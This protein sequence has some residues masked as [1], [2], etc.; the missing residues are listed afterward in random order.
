MA[1][2]ADLHNLP[3]EQREVLLDIAQFTLDVIGIVEPTPFADLTSG[4]ISMFRG[5]WTGAAIS[6]V[7]VVPYIGDL[8]KLGKV[9][10][11]LAKVENAIRLARTNE[12]FAAVLRPVLER[13]RGALDRLPL[14]KV[15]VAVRDALERMRKTIGDFLPAGRAASRLDGLTDDVLRRVFGSTQ[16]VGLLPRQNVRT[17]VEFFDRYKVAG[18][19]AAQWAELLKGIDLHAATPI[20]VTKFKPGELVAEYVELARPANRQIG[21]W[22]VRAQ[23]AVSHRNIGLSG[24]GRVRKVYRVKPGAEVEV[25]QSKAAGAADHWTLAGPKPHTAVTVQNGQRVMKDAEHVAGGGE[26]FFLPNAWQFLEE[27]AGH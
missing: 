26:Q 16:N 22:M 4:V 24:A 17:T 9:P 19:D 15:P 23:G 5:D 11:Y 21:Q 13:L 12:K 7:G 25:L 8:A 6:A 10:K 14:D 20:R 3:P 18:G 1:G 27:V 2:L